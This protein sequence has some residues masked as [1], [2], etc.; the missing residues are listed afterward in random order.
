MIRVKICDLDSVP[1]DSM[2]QFSVD[3]HEFLVINRGGKL[4]CLDGRCTHAG[5]PLAFGKLEGNILTCPWHGSQ[6]DIT[7]GS[8]QRGPAEQNLRV[9][10]LVVKENFCIA[11]MET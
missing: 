8:V 5:A 1:P 11:E 6:F 9:Y 2:K 10:P 3:D 4:H 7:D